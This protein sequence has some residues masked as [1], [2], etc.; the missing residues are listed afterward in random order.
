MKGKRDGSSSGESELKDP[1]RSQLTGTALERAHEHALILL[2]R[3]VA[4]LDAM[5]TRASFLIAALAIGGT[6]LGAILTDSNHKP[7]PWWVVM[8]LWLAIIPC[9]TVLW[10]T[11][12]HGH[13]RVRPDWIASGSADWK[14]S[15]QRGLTDRWRE[16]KCARQQN[17]RLWKVGLNAVDLSTAKNKVAELQLEPTQGPADPTKEPINQVLV[18][19]MY[20]AHE[21]N[22]H[23]LTRRA[24]LFR[25]ASLLALVF[26]IV[27]SSW[28]STTS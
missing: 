13:L 7:P 21:M 16:W 25:A 19:R 12:D 23:T 1:P 6:V 4:V 17:R 11:R 14:L 22:D 9:I 8:W 24:D 2:Q 28:L 20:A 10:S 3:D 18:E 5:R 15:G 26:L 27:F